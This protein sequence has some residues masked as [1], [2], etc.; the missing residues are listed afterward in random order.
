MVIYLRVNCL[1][2]PQQRLH[3]DFDGSY[4]KKWSSFE[5]LAGIRAI[6][7]SRPYYCTS[8]DGHLYLA[9]EALQIL[10]IS[11]IVL[12]HTRSTHKDPISSTKPGPRLVLE[13]KSYS[14]VA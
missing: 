5:P 7:R 2:R 4:S 1:Q 10:H 12:I 3:A 6:R 14:E 13:K 8:H 11:V 9:L